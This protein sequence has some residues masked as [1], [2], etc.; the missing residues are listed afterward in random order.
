MK[1]LHIRR[2]LDLPSMDELNN[3]EKQTGRELPQSFKQFLLTYN[4]I[5]FQESFITVNGSRYVV[6]GFHPLSPTYE[7]SLQVVYTGLNEYFSNGYIAFADDG[8]GWK[9]VLSLQV[10]DFGCTYFCRTDHA[11]PGALTFLTKTFEEFM[12]KLRAE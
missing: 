1:T 12:D 11:P 2:Q 6:D 7:L 8:G 9:F 3:F 4:A 10:A 5:D